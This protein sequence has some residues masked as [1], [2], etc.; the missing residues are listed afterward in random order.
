MTHLSRARLEELLRAFPALGVAVVGDFALDAYWV[1]DMTRSELSRET[2]RFPL[3]IVQ[4]A[5]SPGAAGNVAANVAA[6]GVRRVFAISVLGD[7]WRGR[8]LR[9]ELAQRGVDVS[10]LLTAP[11]RVTCAYIK[12]IRR[13]YN[14]E[15]EDARLDFD[16][17]APLTA[18]TEDRLLATV[19]DSLPHVRTVAVCDQM[20]QGILTP[21]VREGLIRLAREH[22][23]TFFC[24]DSRYRIGLFRDMVLKPNELEAARARRPDRPPQAMERTEL[25][26]IG[27]ELA[28]Q[29]RRPVYITIGAD[30]ALL[31]DG[32]RVAHL[33]APRAQ[34]P[35]DTVGAGDTF[36]AALCAGLAAGASPAEAGALANLAT[37]VTIK[38]LNT[39]GTASPAELRA[40]YE[41]V[42]GT[43]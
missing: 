40:K 21:R 12:P 3:P 23:E 4:E 31:F 1:A 37:A 32:D 33:P 6:L 28:R 25:E 14:S 22:P 7:D 15:Q 20:A 9:E 36:L 19:A 5:Y 16:N 35:I 30:G 17:Y 39:T 2:P 43:W 38:K 11:G 13:G 34:P 18:E 29:A 42:Q 8:I 27:L 41:E 26:A 10:T 24:A